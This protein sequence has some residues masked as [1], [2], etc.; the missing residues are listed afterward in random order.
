M[1]DDGALRE[2]VRLAFLAEFTGGMS[3]NALERTVSV[4]C[5]LVEEEVGDAWA[6]YEE[7]HQRAE[8]AER[9]LNDLAAVLHH[10]GGQWQTRTMTPQEIVEDC[11]RVWNEDVRLYDKWAYDVR[12]ALAEDSTADEPEEED[13]HPDCDLHTGRCHYKCGVKS[14]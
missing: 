8:A 11:V 14:K 7:A 3:P 9:A 10:D 13:H 4:A 2:R 1:S 5:R 6:N 12:M